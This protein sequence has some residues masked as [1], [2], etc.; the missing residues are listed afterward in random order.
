VSNL[1]LP[2]LERHLFAA[3]DILRGK[4]CSSESEEHIFGMVFLKRSSDQFED[5]RQME[6]PSAAAASRRMTPTAGLPAI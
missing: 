3:A 4:M 1:T 2:H 5:E 6:R